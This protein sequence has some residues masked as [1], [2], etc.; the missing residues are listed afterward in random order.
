MKTIIMIGA[1]YIKRYNFEEILNINQDV[2]IHLLAGQKGIEQCK[3]ILQHLNFKHYIS[4]LDYFPDPNVEIL[5]EDDSIKIIG[6]IINN[7][8]ESQIYIYCDDEKYLLLAAKARDY[9]NIKNGLDYKT[10]LLFR[11][12]L[13]MKDHVVE[14]QMYLPKYAAIKTFLVRGDLEQSYSNIISFLGNNLFIAKPSALAGSFGFAKIFSYQDFVNFINSVYDHELNFMVEEFIEGDLFHVDVVLDN[15]QIKH[16]FICEYSAP[17][18]DTIGG[19]LLASIPLPT[20]HSKYVI[21]REYADK[22]LPLFNTTDGAL[23]LELFLNSESLQPTFLEIGCRPPGAHVGKLYQLN[24]TINIFNEHLVTCCGLNFRP[25]IYDYDNIIFCHG[26]VPAKEGVYQGIKM[27]QINSKFDYIESFKNGDV[28]KTSVV[29]G[30][31]A[32]IFEMSNSNYNQLYEDFVK[33]NNIN[34][35]V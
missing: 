26:Y 27:P 18:A 17:N 4:K 13:L 3:S 20:Y 31:H 8:T 21:L 25:V 23:H 35:L 6:E 28:I 32:I 14:N 15:Q 19:A 2:R 10:T 11:D 22:I 7:N 16:I 30:Q 29:I 24:Y 33:I 12:K 34:F 1:N 5:N 9:Y